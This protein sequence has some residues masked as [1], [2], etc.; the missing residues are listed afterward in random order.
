[1]RGLPCICNRALLSAES[2]G[3]G[4]LYSEVGFPFPRGGR[5]ESQQ[6]WGE[7]LGKDTVLQGPAGSLFW[8]TPISFP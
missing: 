7:T 3:P 1:M 4:G 8:T 2:P 6:E 5:N